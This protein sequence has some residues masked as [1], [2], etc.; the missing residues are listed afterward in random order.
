MGVL[1]FP[2][3]GIMETLKARLW[4]FVISSNTQTSSTFRLFSDAKFGHPAVILG[5]DK[6]TGQLL[7]SMT[8]RTTAFVFFFKYC[9]ENSD[10]ITW[11]FY[12]TR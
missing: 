1:G 11:D 4:I 2:A 12:F 6:I 7:P 5:P 9:S 10:G 3:D 8:S